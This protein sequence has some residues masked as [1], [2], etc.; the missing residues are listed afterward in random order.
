MLGLELVR[1][2]CDGR[3]TGGSIGSMEIE[4]HPSQLRGGTF[5][6]DAITAG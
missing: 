3:L 1:D 4:F 2:M 6:A 5:T